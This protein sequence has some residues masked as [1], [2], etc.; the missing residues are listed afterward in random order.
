M[1]TEVS[2]QFR[3]YVAAVLSLPPEELTTTEFCQALGLRLAERPGLANEM[4]GLLRQCDERKFAP[5][6]AA[7]PL[8]AAE[9]AQELIGQLAQSAIPHP[10]SV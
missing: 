9:R 7:A 5:V 2:R 1:V 4:M 6:A 8:G 3:R 10:A